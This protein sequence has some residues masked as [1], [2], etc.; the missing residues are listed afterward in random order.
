MQ[1]AAR[2]L[3]IV[4]ALSAASAVAAPPG[5]AI[6]DLASSD[7][8][9]V[10]DAVT[11]VERGGANAETLFAAARACEQVLLD[12]ARAEN[13]YEHVVYDYP[14]SNVAVPAH[15]RL[16]EL[17]HLLGTDD[18][19]A[20]Q[21]ASFAL[22][23]AHGDAMG[24][25]E[26]RALEEG[27]VE[28]SPRWPGVPDAELW[29]AEY[30]RERG[31]YAAAGEQYARIQR[32]WPSSAQGIEALRGAAG[33]A[34]DAHDWKRA[35]ALA[36]QLPGGAPVARAGR[37]ELRAAGNPIED[38]ARAELIAQGRRGMRRDAIGDA[39]WLAIALAFVVVLASL[40]GAIFRGGRRWPRAR[41]P[42]EVM[43]LGPIAAVL[44]AISFAAQRV[45]GPAVAR[46]TLTGLLLAWISGS[47]LDL[48]RARG[49]PTRGRSLVHAA[50]CMLGVVAMAYLAVV[51][52]G[53]FDMLVE[54]VRNGPE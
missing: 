33:T 17:Q 50:A 44:V 10:A 35:L 9:A 34:L 39:A 24:A 2:G 48:L 3:A 20:T 4:V 38:A 11:A 40:A 7:P 15:R 32:R 45:I 8:R 22:L 21:A 27:L 54:T 42:L 19:F 16:D 28:S 43:F 31:D 47:A 53:L 23:V 14:D 30:L 5:A 6:D 13:L 36:E 1:P 18:E 51:R 49:E 26:V 29:L 46:I 41:P 25:A 12:P 52:D 37:A